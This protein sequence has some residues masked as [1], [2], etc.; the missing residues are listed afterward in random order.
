MKIW[1]IAAILIALAVA[2]YIYFD[3]RA[4]QEQ[5]VAETSS[6]AVPE[7][8]VEPEPESEPE[9]EP[10]PISGAPQFTEDPS[11]DPGT[12]VSAEM[13]EMPLPMLADSDPV[14]LE[15]LEQLLGEPAV[16]RYVVS[17]NVISRIVA[18]VD[19]LGSRKIPGVVQVVNG[20]ETPFL[21]SPN[22]VPDRIIRNEE[23]DVIPQFIID[24]ATYERY[25]PYIELLEAVDAAEWVSIYRD[26]YP[27]FLEAYRQMGYAQ[28][29]FNDRMIAIVD[30]LLATPSVSDPVELLKPEAYFLFTDPD[31][32]ALT[33]GQKIMLRMG[34]QNAM[35]VKEKLREIRALL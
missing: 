16:M 1:V 8:A 22:T 24:P 13:D 15:N 32:E 5:P 6:I 19:T 3:G 7:P 17:D 4:L 34:S 10:A 23:G 18:T 28:G 12:P 29:N 26:Y 2:G 35:R 31:L 27:L 14:V 21:A 11:I 33:A 9:P 30:E 25:T 20:P